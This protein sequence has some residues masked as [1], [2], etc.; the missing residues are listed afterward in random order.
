MFNPNALLF[1]EGWKKPGE[2]H[3]AAWAH[4]CLL[5]GL[6]QGTAPRGDWV[7]SLMSLRWLLGETGQSANQKLLEPPQRGQAW[8][9]GVAAVRVRVDLRAPP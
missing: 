8:A 3:L 4:Q 1:L 6:L 9:L 2:A 7:K 5:T